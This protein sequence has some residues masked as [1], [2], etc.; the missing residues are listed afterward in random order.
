MVPGTS[1]SRNRRAR[2][3]GRMS[4]GTVA[5]ARR[6]RLGGRRQAPDALM[7]AGY[8]GGGNSSQAT[9]RP[10]DPIPDPPVGLLA[11]P[12]PPH[13]ARTPTTLRV[14]R[15]LLEASTT[16]GRSC[17]SDSTSVRDAQEGRSKEPKGDPDSEVTEAGAT[18]LKPAKETSR[19]RSADRKRGRV[20]PGTLRP[21]TVSP[22]LRIWLRQADSRHRHGR[23]GFRSR[24]DG[25]RTP[26]HRR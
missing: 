23:L 11:G 17:R 22:Q 7:F 26:D 24:S 15:A 16:V 18:G 3:A 10:P 8:V 5:R 14:R 2:T 9:A 1:F 19:S 12:A 25:T 6:D 13:P 21:P 4:T 20:F